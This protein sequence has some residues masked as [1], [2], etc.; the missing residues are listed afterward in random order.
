MDV[1]AR[2]HIA[3]VVRNYLTDVNIARMV[4]PPRSPDLN[5]I[6]HIWDNMLR[7]VRTLQP[8]P[9]ALNKLSQSLIHIW[10]NIDQLRP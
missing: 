5:P 2:P 9:M 6:E 4:W 7:E 8:P 1:N 10:N 3:Q